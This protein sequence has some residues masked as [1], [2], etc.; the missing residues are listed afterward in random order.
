MTSKRATM[1]R[2]IAALAVVSALAIGS[3]VLPASAGGAPYLTKKA[4]RQNE[5]IFTTWNDAAQQTPGLGPMVAG[6]IAQSQLATVESLNV[7]AGKYAI[8][9]K[10]WVQQHVG[11]PQHVHCG[12]FAGGDFDHS[13]TQSGQF[14]ASLS[15]EVTHTFSDPGAITLECADDGASGD[16]DAHVQWVKIIAIRANKLVRS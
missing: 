1:I 10:A 7:P 9:A 5:G 15:L 14:D 4:Y 8:F 11:A 12:L 6:P 16:S 13:R 3:T 2:S